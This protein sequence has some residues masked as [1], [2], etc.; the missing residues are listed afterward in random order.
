MTAKINEPKTLVKHMSCECQCQFDDRK[1]NSNQKR[2]NNSV[3]VS[4]KVLLGIQ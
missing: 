1:Q 2:N 4:E 3:S